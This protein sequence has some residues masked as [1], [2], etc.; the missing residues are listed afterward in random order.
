MLFYLQRSTN[1]NTIVYAAN[2][3][4]AGQLDPKAPIDAFC[5]VAMWRMAAAATSTS[6]SA[7][8]L[9]RDSPPR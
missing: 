8:G 4:K 6:F 5:G 2:L 1:G 9:W 3:T 7:P